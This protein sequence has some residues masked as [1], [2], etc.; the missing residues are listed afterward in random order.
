MAKY[1]AKRISRGHYI[2]RGFE[3]H[4]FYY[5]PEHKVCWEATDHDGCGFAHGC[6]LKE[7]KAL[8][9][10]ELERSNIK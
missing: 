1:R 4:G 8:I 5:G 2:Y 10:D 6:S 3:I 7:T 9:D